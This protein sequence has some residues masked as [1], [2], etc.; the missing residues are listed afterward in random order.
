MGASGSDGEFDIGLSPKEAARVLGTSLSTVYRLIDMGKLEAYPAGSTQRR[1]VIARS[2]VNAYLAQARDAGQARARQLRYHHQ[3]I[4]K[5]KYG[6]P[7]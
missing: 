5:I 1:Y 4:R 3:Q 2:A 6:L 7:D